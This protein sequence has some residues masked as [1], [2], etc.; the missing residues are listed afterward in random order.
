M[1]KFWPQSSKAMPQGLPPTVKV[2]RVAPSAARTFVTLLKAPAGLQLPKHHHCGTVMVY[3]IKGSWRSL[4]HDWTAVE[5]AAWIARAL[6]TTLKL[7]GT[8]ADRLRR[9]R[10][11]SNPRTK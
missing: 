11:A 1:K 8:S 6:G 9:S 5:L 4:E 2:P 7:V 3:T 10:D